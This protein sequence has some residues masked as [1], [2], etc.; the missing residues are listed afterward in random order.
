MSK[1]FKG[2]KTSE[3]GAEENKG[4][5]WANGIHGWEEARKWDL[6]KPKGKKKPYRRS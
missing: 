6:K 1:T 5:K 3:C 2:G 4:S